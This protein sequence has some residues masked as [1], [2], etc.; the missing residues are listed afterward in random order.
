[1]FAVKIFHNITYRI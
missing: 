1:L